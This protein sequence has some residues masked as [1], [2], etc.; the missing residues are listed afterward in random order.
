M[1]GYV[2]VFRYR[3]GKRVGDW[4]SA[5]LNNPPSSANMNSI[6]KIVNGAKCEQPNPEYEKPQKQD[7]LKALGRKRE[8]IGD[9]CKH[10]G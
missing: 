9:H 5:V 3:P 8:S 7:R 6:I 1:I 10:I 2:G 4:N